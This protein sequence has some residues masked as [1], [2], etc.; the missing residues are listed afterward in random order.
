MV[1]IDHIY[2][3]FLKYQQVCTDS[4]KVSANTI[5]FALKGENFNGNL[6]AEKALNSGASFAIVDEDLGLDSSKVLLVD[7]VLKCLQDFANR[8][9]HAFDIPVVAIT[10]SNGKTTTKE[11]IAS[12]LGS[13]FNTHFTLGN[14][15]NHIGVPLTLLQLKKEHQI[16]FIEMGANHVGEIDFLCQIA[17]PTHG[18][19]TNIGKAHLEGFGG[20]EGV[21]KGKG[22][23]YDFLMDT[24]GVIF[25]N[26][27]ESSLDELIGSRSF[28]GVYFSEH[29]KEQGFVDLKL[30]DNNS[31]LSMQV[32]YYDNVTQDI[33]TQ[34]QGDYNVFNALSAICI[35]IYFRVPKA[36]IKYA[37]ES[38]HPQ[39][40]RS[41]IVTHKSNTFLLDAYNANPSSML[42]ALEDFKKVNHERKIAILGDMY[43]LGDY[44]EEE[45][46]RVADLALASGFE[47]VVFVGKHFPNSDFKDIK[48]LK[49][50][51]LCQEYKDYF[52]LIKG[53]RGV[54]L[55]KLLQD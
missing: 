18:I 21:K 51:F 10:G 44:S 43:E 46:K 41:Q 23:L 53:S 54:A 39:N 29:S 16:A 8:Y 12:V 22:E 9:R 13:N 33:Q 31:F 50:W 25:I 15:N 32:E 1:T 20:M 52:F 38:Y 49:E 14:F 36:K 42:A 5:F 26:Q 17:N 3:H 19:I 24:N 27:S 40:N 48:E 6:F 45:H 2:T 34:L 11:L 7:D 55:E 37:L 35:G 4:R 28:K 47:K 30:T